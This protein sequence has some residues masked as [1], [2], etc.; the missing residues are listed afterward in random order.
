[1]KVNEQEPFENGAN[2][3]LEQLGKDTVD[4]KGEFMTTD[5]GVKINDDQNTLKAG[6]RGPSV[7]EDI[8]CRAQLTHVD[9][10]RIPKRIV[11]ARG[12][13]ADGE[14]Q[15]YK[16]MAK[17][18]KAKFLNDTSVKTPV[19]ARFS[20]VQGSRGSTDLPRD[21]RGFAVKFYTQEGNYDLVGNNMPVFFIQDAMKFPDLVH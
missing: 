1:M 9:Q 12:S 8:I 5:H 17:Y 10:G 13:G 21:V 6:E 7:L 4:D 16:S 15:L 11:H 14:F 20:T 2:P 18:T 3:K 19:F